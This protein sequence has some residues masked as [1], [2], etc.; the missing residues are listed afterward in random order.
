[1][2]R[3][4]LPEVTRQKRGACVTVSGF[5]G[6]YP[7]NP[8]WVWVKEGAA[9]AKR[10]TIELCLLLTVILAHSAPLCGQATG[11][12]AGRKDLLPAVRTNGA[13][14][15]FAKIPP[16]ANPNET[17][18]WDAFSWPVRPAA[19]TGRASSDGCSLMAE[20]QAVLTGTALLKRCEW[21]SG[22]ATWPRGYEVD[23][24]QVACLHTRN[25]RIQ[26][27]LAV[28]KIQHEAAE[29]VEQHWRGSTQQ[30][31]TVRRPHD[32]GG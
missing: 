2:H 17:W 5:G 4:Q 32:P 31:G 13:M 10:L 6:T 27:H 14:Q 29:D 7:E 1:M 28:A 21:A 8:P 16:V 11:L 12:S 26:R 24:S 20:E 22:M 19:A 23:G 15:G 9:G 30:S 3:S 25:L 18:G